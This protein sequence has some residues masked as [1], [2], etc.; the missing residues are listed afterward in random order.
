MLCDVMESKLQYTYEDRDG[1]GRKVFK[2]LSS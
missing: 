2:I 1:E